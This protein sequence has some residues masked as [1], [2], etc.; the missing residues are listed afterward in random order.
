MRAPVTREKLERFME[1]LGRRSQRPAQIF[2]TGG[3]TAVL[4]GWR[5]STIDID[6]FIEPGG[7]HVLRHVPVL[8]EELQVNVELAAPHDFIPPLDGW[9]DRS[10][11]VGRRGSIDFFHYDYEA[12]ALS[13]LERAHE[14]DLKD[15]RLMASHGLIQPD[16]LLERFGEL[17]DELYRYPAID[18]TAFERRVREFVAGTGE[19]GGLIGDP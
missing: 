17:R 15:V 9:R 8:K 18:V 16:R 14:R 7:D 6:L 4:H 12:Q 11:S 13:K 1:E 3:A 5:D 19:A 10:P 2:F